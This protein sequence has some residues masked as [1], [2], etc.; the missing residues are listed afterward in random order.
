MKKLEFARA[1]LYGVH[2]LLIK[3]HDA[4]HE[5]RVAAPLRRWSLMA[6]I[7]FATIGPL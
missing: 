2:F 3:D 1:C 5:R 4:R 6:A 7:L